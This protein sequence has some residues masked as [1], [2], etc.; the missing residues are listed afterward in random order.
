VATPAP[1]PS[2]GE[3]VEDTKDIAEIQ[4]RLYELNYD[5]GEADGVAGAR[6]REAISEFQKNAGLD[7][8]G[9]ATRGLLT[10]LKSL[11]GLKPWGAIVYSAAR[12][13]WGMAWSAESR[14]QAIEEAQSSCGK[15]RGCE[16]ELTFFGTE[17]GA[18]AH[19]D[20][21][22]AIVARTSLADAKKAALEEC[23][24]NCR[25][26]ATVCADGADEQVAAE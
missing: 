22:W 6:T 20:N 11:G 26:I 25:V 24:G 23:R 1:A 18:F 2:D 3:P 10:R 8:D 12:Q 14:K 9:K 16:A 7:A 4:E 15:N 13:D 21:G 5:P 19:S 17:C